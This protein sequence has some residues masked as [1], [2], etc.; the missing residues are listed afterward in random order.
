[1]I[2][3]MLDRHICPEIGAM[4]AGEITKRDVIR[5]LDAVAAK[6]DARQ[7]RKDGTR[8]RSRK[9]THRP[10]RVFELVRAIF[11]WA[12]GR[13]LL[14]VDPTFGLSPPIKKEKA[15]ERELSP[16]GDTYAMVRSR[17]ARPVAARDVE[18]A[19][20]ATSQCVAPRPS[21]SSLRS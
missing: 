21:R 6:V 8:R 7:E 1:M 13:D 3:S 19:S 11:R 2:E 20:G 9:L 5:L 12:V 15:R 17:L 10:N 18:S 16:R 14:K 4:K